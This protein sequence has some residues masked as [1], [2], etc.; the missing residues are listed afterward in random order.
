MPK[1]A[2]HLFEV[3]F[4]NSDPSWERQSFFIGAPQSDPLRNRIAGNIDDRMTLD[5]LKAKFR[6]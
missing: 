6:L 5:T 1:R 2:E 4:L 3:H